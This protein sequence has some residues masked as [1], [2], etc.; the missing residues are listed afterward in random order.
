MSSLFR[1]PK[2]PAPMD[3]NAVA[4]QQKTQNTQNAFQSAAFNRVN[5][6]GPFGSVNWSQSGTD[7]QGNPVF[8]Q[9]TTLD[10]GEVAARNQQRDV[11]MGGYQQG[12][13]GIGGMA[14]SGLGRVETDPYAIQQ[15]GASRLGG[16]AQPANLSS[17]AAF[18]QAYQTAS[19]NI[20]PRME[21]QRAAMENRL[22]NQGL[23]PTSEAYKSGMSDLALQQ[24]EARND[25]TTKLQ[26]QM[27]NQGLAGRQQDFSEASG[28]FGIGAGEAQR[29]FGQDA[30]GFQQGLGANQA[31]G[32][33][34]RS[35]LVEG[36]TTPGVAGYNGVNVGNVDMVGLNQQAQDQ[37]WKRYQNEVSQRNAM[38]GGLASIGGSILSAPMTGGTSLAGMGAKGI[39]NWMSPQ[40]PI[41]PWQTT[42]QGA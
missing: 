29:L 11:S 34:G 31:L 10:P 16:M 27:F 7:A 26:G 35:G 14:D 28:L 38:L 30:T 6:Q 37:E 33:L 3:V 39:A 12:M 13:Q 17:G 40:K 8:S 23:D 19:A 25:L 2:A 20:E 41:G 5:Q 32:S 4:N 18:D 42:V 1:S 36:A 15:A 22:R 21:R 9:A 24:N